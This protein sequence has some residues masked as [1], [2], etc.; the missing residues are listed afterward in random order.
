MRAMVFY[1]LG[2]IIG[3][4]IY[5]LIGKI[6]G[7]AGAWTPFAFLIA[8]VISS[9]TGFSY[10]ELVARFPRSAGEAV[11]IQQAFRQP[12]LSKLVGWLIVLTGVVSASTLLKGFAGYFISLLG[13][14]ESVVIAITLGSICLLACIGVKQSV[15]LAVG[16]TL[17]ELI[18]LLLVV[19]VSAA[20]L[21]EAANWQQ[22]ADELHNPSWAGIAGASF[23]AFYAFIGFE[24]MANMAEEVTNV[25]VALPKA[26][27]IA[28]AS[29]AVIYF[30]IGLVAVVAVPNAELAT[31][32]SPLTTMVESS[33]WFPPYL[34]TLIS[35][36]AIVNGAIV[37]VLM[38]PRVIY[39]ITQD[40]SRLGFLGAI[41]SRTQTP[42]VA[43]IVVSVAIFGFTLWLPVTQLAQATSAII[44]CLFVL[45]NSALVVIKRRGAYDG[46]QVYLA[47]PVL[48]VLTSFGLLIAQFII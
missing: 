9:F 47:V 39:G 16:I 31:S 18:G 7:S 11:Y 36:I 40:S 21:T 4:G 19:L 10:A 38:A 44:L 29:S 24:D 15:G 13:G 37:Q 3:A 32:Q 35:L 30:V 45:I 48:G 8:A 28:I 6:T 22:W 25:S 12:W 5:V 2:T 26:I 23:L 17:L 46:F 43:T 34:I 20:P 33:S 42:V 27:I 1:G 14:I 41:Y